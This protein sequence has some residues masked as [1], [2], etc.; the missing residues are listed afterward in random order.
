MS[1]EPILSA[2]VKLMKDNNVLSMAT[3]GSDGKVDFY[4]SE[5]IYTICASKERYLEQCTSVFVRGDTDIELILRRILEASAVTSGEIVP[6]IAVS[7]YGV[8]CC[9]V[10][11]FYPY[12]VAGAPSDGYGA[13]F[14]WCKGDL[15]ENGW[16]YVEKNNAEPVI[17]DYRLRSKATSESYNYRWRIQYIPFDVIDR[18]YISFK[19]GGEGDRYLRI[20]LYQSLTD[21]YPKMVFEIHHYKGAYT[22]KFTMTRWD[23]ESSSA[24]YYYKYS[25]FWWVSSEAYIR[26]DVS[27]KK[28][29]INY[30]NRY[31]DTLDFGMIN[32]I[33]SPARIH[34]EAEVKN[35]DTLTT[36]DKLYPPL[37]D[38]IGLVYI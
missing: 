10:H 15:W 9:I 2:I 30:D 35:R 22:V 18:V 26:W 31:T 1:Y 11:K 38:W 12:T 14:T 25:P 27:G 33:S 36:I 23:S 13:L 37:I 6:S 20:I 28:V 24:G 19:M 34:I 32:P 17:N 5:D 16:S 4:V 29:Y 7:D 8:D 21:E 3:T